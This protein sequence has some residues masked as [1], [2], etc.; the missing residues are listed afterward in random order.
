MEMIGSKAAPAIRTAS[1]LTAHG[2][3]NITKRSQKS[4]RIKQC[5]ERALSPEGTLPKPEPLKNKA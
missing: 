3:G 1:N 5:S 2:F 4:D